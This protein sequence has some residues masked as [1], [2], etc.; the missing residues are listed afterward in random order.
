MRKNFNQINSHCYSIVTIKDTLL[1]NATF[2]LYFKLEV[3][4][5]QAKYRQGCIYC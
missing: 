5:T 1:L 4:Y 3:W 2:G